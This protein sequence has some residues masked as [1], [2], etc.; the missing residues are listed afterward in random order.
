MPIK[1]TLRQKLT[2]LSGNTPCIIDF[3]D[4]TKSGRPFELLKDLSEDELNSK[5][6]GNTYTVY[7]T[8]TR[9]MKIKVR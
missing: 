9:E 1:M 4:Y 7:A 2:R 3:G 8:G 5:Y 6:L